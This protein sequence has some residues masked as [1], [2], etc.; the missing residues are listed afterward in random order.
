MNEL[1]FKKTKS[2]CSYS[3]H[4]HYSIIC[5]QFLLTHFCLEHHPKNLEK[6]HEHANELFVVHWVVLSINVIMFFLI[7][8]NS[9]SA[10]CNKYVDEHFI[11]D[12]SNAINHKFQ[13]LD[14]IFFTQNKIQNEMIHFKWVLFR[15]EKRLKRK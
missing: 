12:S 8:Y 9:L 1:C 6:I 3:L 4:F 5:N 15:L 13:K 2:V 10:V 11:H 14:A 7:L